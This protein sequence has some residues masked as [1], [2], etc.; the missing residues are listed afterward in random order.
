MLDLELYL[1]DK[2]QNQRGALNRPFGVSKL[3]PPAEG[4][5]TVILL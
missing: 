2:Q 3:D 5:N 1:R 4:E